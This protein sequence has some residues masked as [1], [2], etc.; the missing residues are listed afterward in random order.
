MQCNH[1]DAGRCRSCTLLPVSYLRQV[2]DLDDDIRSRLRDF[3][4]DELWEPPATGPEAGFRNKA[5]MVVSGSMNNPVL[6]ILDPGGTGV[7]LTDCGLYPPDL[8]GSF[9]VVEDFI[10]RA[11]LVPYE[12]GERRGELKYVIVT[13]SP[14]GHLMVRFVMR[15]QEAVARIRKHL[16]W[17]TGQL[18]SIRV[19]SVNIQP[20]H[21]AV[22]E[23]E[24][25]IVLTQNN[26]LPM[27]LGDVTL[28]LPPRSFF[29]TNSV[30]A[31]E[32]YETARRWVDHLDPGMVLD[33]YCGTG[34]FAIFLAG[35]G[36]RTVGV[37]TSPEAVEGARESARRNGVE[38]EFH[39]GDAAAVAT[40]VDGEPDLV[41]VNPPRRGIGGQLPSWLEGCG[42]R[43][44]LYSSC[45]P[46]SLAL[47]LARMPSFRVCRARVLD[48][49]P[50][51]G[52]AEVL[53]L[54]E[55]I[56]PHADPVTSGDGPHG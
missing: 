33:L 26:S 20:R 31:Q 55:R 22:L 30:V 39:V 35:Q 34:G 12:V 8:Q 32:L 9:A 47:D 18:P 23:G 15:S 27:R 56:S 13:R 38:A 54:L 40:V 36:R 11:A 46:D 28:N 1:F 4:A 43:A 48:M 10:S 3:V 50:H 53:V 2:S 7:D 41:V 29:Q 21:A 37:E 51:T 17:L 6:G 14:D 19:V 42:A 45:S 24:M 44:V 49:F 25:E 16:P 52:H 5:K